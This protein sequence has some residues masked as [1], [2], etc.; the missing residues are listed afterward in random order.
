MNDG[1]FEVTLV[2]AA[3]PLASLIGPLTTLFAETP[4]ERYIE[5]F[6][7]DS[8]HVECD[9]EVEWNLDGEYGGKSKDTV[10]RVMQAAVSIFV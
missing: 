5:R 6:Q 2:K 8:L 4:D 3:K 9:E 7:T 1:L 10:I